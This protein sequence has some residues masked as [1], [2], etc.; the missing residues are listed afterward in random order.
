MGIGQRVRG[1]G[2]LSSPIFVV[3]EWPGR[4]EAKSGRPFSPRGKTGKEIDRFFDGVTLPD[5]HGIY[6]TDWIKEW[7]GEDGE[8][9]QEDFDR[10]EPELIAE[11]TAV[12]PRVIVPLGRHITRYLLGDV[13]M[14]EVH[15]IP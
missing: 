4:E 1:E 7:C 9:T 14:D 11:L 10:D 15:G 3:G 6:L 5:R 2:S 13:D 12:Q 8:Y